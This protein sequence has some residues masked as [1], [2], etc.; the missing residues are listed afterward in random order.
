MPDT[1][2][3]DMAFIDPSTYLPGWEIPQMRKQLLLTITD[4]R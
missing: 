2:R 4:C 1:I 3:D